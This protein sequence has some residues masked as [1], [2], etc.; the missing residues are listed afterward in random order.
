MSLHV[1][2]KNL[3]NTIENNQNITRKE[4]S[5]KIRYSNIEEI[6]LENFS[7]LFSYIK[8]YKDLQE[9][10][11]NLIINKNKNILTLSEFY[12]DKY[13]QKLT[14]A[15]INY[16][17]KN[18]IKWMNEAKKDFII[19][20]KIEKEQ[21]KEEERQFEKEYKRQ[22]ELEKTQVKQA[23]IDLKKRQETFKSILQLIQIICI[24]ALSPLIFLG[25]FILAIAKNS[26]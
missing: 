24:V 10:T 11:K 19:I 18:Y 22:R 6:A 21:Q 23:Q 15:N 3:S 20:N 26:K 25:F 13:N 14:K 17:A 2:L 4:Q 8:N 5:E 7:D 9:L 16:I 1:D 12:F